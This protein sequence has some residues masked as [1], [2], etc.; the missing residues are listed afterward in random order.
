MATGSGFW[1]VQPS[2]TAIVPS[3]PVVFFGTFGY[4]INI[5]RQHQRDARFIRTR[6]RPCIDTTI[7][8]VDP[9]DSINISLGMGLSLNEQFS[10]SLGFKYD[11]IFPTTEEIDQIDNNNPAN[12]FTR[13]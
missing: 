11:Y 8:E 5:R 13:Q 4:T 12:N 7:G 6:R 9:G 3:D 10:M 1:G 2:I